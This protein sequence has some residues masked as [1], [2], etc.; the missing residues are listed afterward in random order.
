MGLAIKIGT[1]YKAAKGSASEVE[2]KRRKMGWIK[3][4]HI[5]AK[6]TQKAMED[7]KP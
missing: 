4:R 5:M 1:R 6:R 7:Q 2:P 3:Q